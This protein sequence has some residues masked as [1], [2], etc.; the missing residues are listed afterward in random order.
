M[1]RPAG[2]A[3]FCLLQLL[4]RTCSLRLFPFCHPGLVSESAK[5]PRPHGDNYLSVSHLPRPLSLLSHDEVQN[6][7]RAVCGLENT[8]APRRTRPRFMRCDWLRFGA[9]KNNCCAVIFASPRM[10]WPF[11]TE[12]GEA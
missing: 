4:L 5:D 12:G 6:R 9:C 2:A 1:L 11:R 3:I 10:L 7:E 8:H